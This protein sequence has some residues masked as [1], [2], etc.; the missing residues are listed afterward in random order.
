MFSGPS[1]VLQYDTLWVSLNMITSS[2]TAA[3]LAIDVSIQESDNLL[4]INYRYLSSWYQFH[5]NVA[6]LWQT[7]DFTS[8]IF[9]GPS[10]VFQCVTLWVGLQYDN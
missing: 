4:T 10:T 1:T 6:S 9:Y 5:N 2:Q 8:G 7:H 3:W